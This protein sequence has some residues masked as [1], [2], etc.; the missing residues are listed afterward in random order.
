[1]GHHLTAILIQV[2]A[3][4][5]AAARFDLHPIALTP[6][7]TMF[8]VDHYYTAYWQSVCGTQGYLDAPPISIFPSERVVLTIVRALTQQ[9]APRFAIVMTD[10]F[11]GVGSQSAAVYT[12]ERRTTGDDASINDAL[13][14]LGVVRREGMDEFDTVQLG[15]H[16]RPSAHLEKYGALCDERGV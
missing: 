13:V 5:A 14:A 1:M 12:G 3:D 10:Y 15:N 16:R 9:E 11:G 2:A 6:M 4:A 7:L 8:L